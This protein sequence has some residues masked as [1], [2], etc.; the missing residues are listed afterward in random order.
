MYVPTHFSIEELV[1]PTV[2][3]ARGERSWQL[4]DE[5]MLQTIDQMR[6]HFGSMVINTWHSRKLQK[7]FGLRRQSGL[8]TYD[9]YLEVYGKKQAMEKY[10]NSYS[11]HKYG[12]AFDCIFTEFANQDSVRK[13]VRENPTRFPFLTSMETG[14]SWFHGDCRNVRPLLEFRP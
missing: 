13:R 12:R 3:E 5:Q 1:P 11:Q 10:N 8:R 9:F 7:R 6:E 2:Y 4:L 14:I